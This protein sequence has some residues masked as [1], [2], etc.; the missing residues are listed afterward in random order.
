MSSRILVPAFALLLSATVLHAQP[1][2]KPVAEALPAAQSSGH[3]ILL[4]L[5]GAAAIDSNGDRWIAQAVAT[6]AVARSLDELVLAAA[7]RSSVTG[8]LPDLAQFRDGKRHLLLLDPWGG[9]ILEL[10]GGFGDVTRFAAALNALRQQAGAFVRAGSQRREGQTAI[11]TITWA[12]GLLDAGYVDEAREIFEKAAS[13]AKRG[14][15]PE[16]LQSAQLGLAAIDLRRPLT[17]TRGIIVLE[18]LAAHPANHEIGSGA[19]MIL[20]QIYRMRSQTAKAIDAFQHSFDLA[21]KPSSLAESARRHLDALGSEPQSEVQADVAAGNVHILYPHRDVLVGI[22][23]IGVA[24]S[25]DAARVEVF[26]DDA[27]VAKLTRRPFRADVVLGPTPHVRTIRAVAWDAQERQ[28]GEERVTLNDRAVAL[29]VSIVA[30]LTDRV[31]TH[32]SVEVIPRLPQGRKL[33]GVDLYWNETKITTLTEPPFRHEVTLPSPFAAGYIRAVA[34]D[35]TGATAEDVKLLNTAGGSERI[36]VDAV[37]VYAIVQDR[38]HYV[39]G[40]TAADFIVKEDGLAVTAQVQSGKADPIALGLALDTSGSMQV[41]MTDVI[42]YANEFVKDSL[43]AADRTFVVAFDEQPHLIQPLTSDRVRVTASIQDVYAGG[44]TAI[45]DA[46]LYSLQ[47]LRGVEGKRALVVFTDCNNNAGLATPGGVLQYAREIGVP[48]YVV[49]IFTGLRE[50]GH[51]HLPTDDEANLMRIAKATGGAFFPFAR[52]V[53]LPR[54]FAQIRDDT[55]GEY[56]LTY[57]S[58][59]GKSRDELRKITVEVPGR[60]L[61]VRAT[62][63]YY[64][65]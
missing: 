37:Q 1:A 16:N 41:S 38:G 46:I 21:P 42:D 15:D 9:V 18:D 35:D 44:G 28:L 57:V 8:M 33:A 29:G 23:N 3:L 51:A 20:G 45:W 26:L 39:D 14:H 30:P 12:G 63:G 43:G 65:R 36:G 11:S 10:D 5:R 52:K 59:G 53:D 2:W 50:V 47:Q 17:I 54:I 25:A 48:L 6:P 58:P 56:L 49:E 40:L 13:A 7:V 64:P 19:W 24:T 55:R 22:V 4:D 60:R 32:A 61:S 27:R 62:S 34:R 31:D